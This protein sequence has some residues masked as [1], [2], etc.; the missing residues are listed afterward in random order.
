MQDVGFG[1][2]RDLPSPCKIFQVFAGP[3]IFKKE[4]NNATRPRIFCQDQSR[5]IFQ[6]LVK[7]NIFEYHIRIRIPGEN[8]FFQI[9]VFVFEFFAIYSNIF[10]YIIEYNKIV[11]Y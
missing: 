8:F 1:N 11:K 3:I 4:Q 9:F 10:E 7:T 6:L 2:L 5:G